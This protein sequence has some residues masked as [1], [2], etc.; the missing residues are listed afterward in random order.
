VFVHD[1]GAG[2]LEDCQ[3]YDNVGAGVEI[4]TGGNPTLRG[5]TIAKNRGHGIRV[6]SGGRATV[7]NCDLRGNE[8][9]AWHI[10]LFSLIS[11][12]RRNNKT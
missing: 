7:E 2:L 5:C 1:G 9:G 4:T 3:I 8:K 11:V 12:K 6:E 10:G